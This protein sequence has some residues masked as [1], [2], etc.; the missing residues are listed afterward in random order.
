MTLIPEVELRTHTIPIFFDMMQCEF[1]SS[2]LELESFGDT[3]RDSSHIKANFGEFENE[4][5]VKLDAL[6]EG[7]RGD[8]EY[9]ELFYNIMK[10][11]CEKHTTMRDEGIKFVEVVAR[12]MESLLEYRNIISNDNKESTMSCTV[13]LLVGFPTSLLIKP[14]GNMFFSAFRTSTRRSTR[15]RCTFGT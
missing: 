4:M 6:F 10:E 1:Y 15:R 11:L 3:K 7:G 12:L 9:K 8:C 13:N 14:T 2:K 5:I